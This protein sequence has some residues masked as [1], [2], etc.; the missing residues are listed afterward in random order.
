[1]T[2][3]RRFESPIRVADKT[4]APVSAGAF[5]RFGG[6]EFGYEDAYS[7]SQFATVARRTSTPVFASAEKVCTLTESA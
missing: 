1:M 6:G 2:E 4:N 3:R 5:V 7:E